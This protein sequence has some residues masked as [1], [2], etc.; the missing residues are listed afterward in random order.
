MKRATVNALAKARRRGAV[1]LIAL[2]LLVTLGLVVLGLN[3]SAQLLHARSY[4][5]VAHVQA[6]WLAR[7]GVERGLERLAADVTAYDWPGDPWYEDPAAFDNVAL[8]KGFV[9]HVTAP[10]K[11]GDADDAVR[12]GLDDEASRLCVNAYGVAAISSLPEMNENIAAA[13]ADWRDHNEEQ[14]PGGAERAYY[15]DLD[16]PYDIANRP[17]R[18]ARELLLAKEITPDLFFRE[19]ANR[20]G[21]LDFNESDGNRL[22]PADN[23]DGTLDRGLA[24]VASTYAYRLN[25]TLTNTQPLKLDSLNAAE[26]QARFGFSNG[27]AEEAAQLDNPDNIFDLVDLAGKGPAEE[28]EINEIDFAWVAQHFEDFTSQDNEV[29]GGRAN[30]NTARREVLEALPQLTDAAVQSIM[31]LRD[32]GQSITQIGVLYTG[33]TLTE[34]DF[35]AVA[36]R[37]T[38]RSNTF[39]VLSRGTAPSGATVTVEAII[40]RGGSRPVLLYWHER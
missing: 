4:G 5:N 26:L 17:F 30:V 28:G 22:P 11:H 39:R 3:R 33:G 35:R 23:A 36:E 37:L 21:S 13:I 25:R 34:D 38:V 15:A 20:N 6:R 2:W 8:A 16:F 24:G 31:S 1:L 10:P 27:L 14:R 40:D 32:Q 18:T 29:L 9:F 12:F 7:A 19:D